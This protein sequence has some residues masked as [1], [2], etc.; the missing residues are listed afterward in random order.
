MSKWFSNFFYDFTDV[1]V[2]L[3]VDVINKVY[4]YEQREQYLL[5]FLKNVLPSS[6]IQDIGDELKKVCEKKMNK[7]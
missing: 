2:P 4:T 3:P 7:K 5:G 6:D 1:C